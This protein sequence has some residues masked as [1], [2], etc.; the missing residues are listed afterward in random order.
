MDRDP[1]V[2]RGHDPEIVRRHGN[3]C[4]NLNLCL[5]LGETQ[6]AQR[7]QIRELSAVGP[8]VVAAGMDANRCCDRLA[9]AASWCGPVAARAIQRRDRYLTGPAM[10]L[11]VP[12]PGS[13]FG[14]A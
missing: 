9:L 10:E 13:V 12:V 8:S 2:F 3:C 14:P 6:A 5:V 4:W 7:A 11:A 1:E